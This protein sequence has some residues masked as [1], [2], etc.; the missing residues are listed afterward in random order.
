VPIR[1]E[2]VSVVVPAHNEET[3]IVRCLDDLA[4]L[5]ADITVVANGCAD[6]T[7]ERVRA[8]EQESGLPVRLIELPVPSKTAAI[9]AGLAAVRGR[10]VVICDADID[11]PPASWQA[12]VDAVTTPAAVIAVPRVAI[13]TANSAAVVRRWAT[14]WSLLP[15]VRGGVVGSGVLAVS[16]AGAE[17]IA[18]LP[19]VINDDG[20]I[21]RAGGYWRR[22]AVDAVFGIRAPLTGAALIRRRARVLLGNRQLAALLGPD[23]ERTPAVG[24]PRL[25]RDREITVPDAVAYLWIAVAARLVAG[26]RVIRGRRREWA[27]DR[28]TRQP[29]AA[30]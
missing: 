24:L 20:W 14:V 13:R 16:A 23:P 3:L 6:R 28:T 1:N 30:S 10:P 9:R 11:M 2:H 26:Y 29:A 19:D 27:A 25:L 22:M 21:R 7:G 4:R 17:R 12:I 18:D 5:A 15:Y 8:W